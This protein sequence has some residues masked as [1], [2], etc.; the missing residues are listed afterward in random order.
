[1]Q[2]HARQVASPAPAAPRR[3]SGVL[4]GQVKG[5]VKS[6]VKG[7]VKTSRGERPPWRSRWSRRGKRKVTDNTGFHVELEQTA[8]GCT[9][10]REVK[11]IRNL[12]PSCFA[13]W[14]AWHAEDM[15]QAAPYAAYG[16]PYAAA[17]AAAQ[18]VAA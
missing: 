8:G 11:H 13:E 16:D 5:K 18:A 2:N 6:Q 3:R 15:R 17:A 7:K 4:L 14:H 1:M 9:C 12:C 10:P